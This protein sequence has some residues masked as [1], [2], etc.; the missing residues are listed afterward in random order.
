LFLHVNKSPKNPAVASIYESFEQTAKE[1]DI[2]F[3]VIHRR[4]NI[5]ETTIKWQH[6]QFSR[7]RIVAATLSGR[8]ESG[9]PGA[10]GLFDTRERLDLNRLR[11]N[12]Q[13]IAEVLVK[14]IYQIS[15]VNASVISFSQSV[16]EHF[17]ESW[18]D[19]LGREPRTVTY[20]AKDQPAIA[21]IEEA[22]TLYTSD[23]K[24]TVF[25]AD[26]MYQFYQ[27][28]IVS[29]L[30][31]YRVKPVFFDIFLSLAVVAYL[32]VLH[33]VVKARSLQDVINIITFRK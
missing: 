25:S 21:K 30:S 14:Q 23:A 28:P 6:E 22:L 24:R 26:N 33:I 4:V 9:G 29:E 31:V 2:P 19:F 32:I 16:N 13:F 11:T 20:I 17:V 15:V 5:S 8:R 18:I 12:I 3:S 27:A 1:M 7:K 10:G